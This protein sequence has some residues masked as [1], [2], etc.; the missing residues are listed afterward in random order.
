MTTVEHVLGRISEKCVEEYCPIEDENSA[1]DDYFIYKHDKPTHLSI[2]CTTLIYA[3]SQPL[4]IAIF[5]LPFLIKNQTP[6]KPDYEHLVERVMPNL[7]F[8]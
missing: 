4:N 8:T 3:P 5:I 6:E 1:F 7:G 2:N